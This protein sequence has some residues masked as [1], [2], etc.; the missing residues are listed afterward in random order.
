[1]KNTNTYKA[2]FY[3][4][5]ILIMLVIG[6]K[7]GAQQKVSISIHQD[8]KLA[9]SGDGY[10]KAGTV[11]LL[12]R[13]KMQGHQQKKGYMVVF[14]E[15]EYADIDGIY[16]RYSANLGYTFN[17][18]VRNFDFSAYGGYGFIDRY[19][20]SMFSFGGSLETAYVIG[21]LKISLIA[22]FTERK[23]LLFLHGNNEVRFSG[24]FGIE[25]NLN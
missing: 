7:A 18:W 20:K 25:Y 4:I 5:L 19:G 1:M 10:Y 22:Q 13:L 17:K 23:D 12:G 8:A 15:F 6:I 24:F 21:D 3:S 9:F 14:P 16:K 11:N 2:C